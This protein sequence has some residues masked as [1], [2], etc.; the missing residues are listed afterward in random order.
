M[1]LSDKFLTT[2]RKKDTFSFLFI[3]TI[4]TV[5]F[6]FLGGA[7]MLASPLVFSVAIS[8]S[9]GKY[10]KYDYNF[11]LI[12]FLFYI[13]YFGA[14][15][16]FYLP[17]AQLQDFYDKN[18]FFKILAAWLG[19]FCAISFVVIVV[20]LTF[21]GI[22]IGM[23]QVL[24]TVLLSLISIGSLTLLF[25]GNTHDAIENFWSIIFF[26]QISMTIVIVSSLKKDIDPGSR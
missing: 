7:F 24:L 3:S 16:P 20:K 10:R 13:L 11:L 26:Y 19:C 22:R 18:P 14:T 1:F 25:K 15:V 9:N 2:K 12:T 4:G 8:L 23:G 5:L 17:Y 6:A 21:K